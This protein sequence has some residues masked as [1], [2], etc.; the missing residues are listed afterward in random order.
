MVNKY[1]YLSYFQTADQ[2]VELKLIS[3]E[4]KQRKKCE[5][6]Q[7]SWKFSVDMNEPEK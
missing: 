7:S 2:P 6:K 1:S 4:Q 3:T 5:T